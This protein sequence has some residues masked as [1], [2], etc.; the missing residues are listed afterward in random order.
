MSTERSPL[1][2]AVDGDNLLHNAY[3]GNKHFKG[4]KDGVA[5]NGVVTFF[6]MLNK[7]LRRG[8]YTHLMV[9][10]DVK[11]TKT[12]RFSILEKHGI[13]YKDRESKLN[14]E[15]IARRLDIHEQKRI[16]MKLLNEYGIPYYISPHESDA[17]EADDILASISRSAKM[18]VHIATT[19]KDL[20]QT[21]NKRVSIYNTRLSKL[22]TGVNCEDVFGVEP[23]KVVDYLRLLG[24]SSDNIPGI[25]GCGNKTAIK[26]LEEYGD[27]ATIYA[28]RRKLKGAVSKTF[29]ELDANPEHKQYLLDIKKCIKLNYKIFKEDADFMSGIATQSM[30]LDNIKARVMKN[31]KQILKAKNAIGFENDY[32]IK[33]LENKDD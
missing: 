8:Y 28:N 22:I 6:G 4:A 5:I 29:A 16:V 31:R 15:Q 11:Y 18:D 13:V 21:I 32:L 9:A 2:L 12:R 3:H 33:E 10:W 24:D 27:F 14:D 26:L 25:K 1:L 23:D 30:C 19:D 7:I 20:Y 17:D